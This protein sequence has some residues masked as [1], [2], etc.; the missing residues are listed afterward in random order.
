MPRGR[1]RKLSE[2]DVEE[3]M[4]RLVNGETMAALAQEYAV[5]KTTM[6]RNLTGRLTRIQGA[7]WRLARAEMQL[8]AMPPEARRAVCDLVAAMRAGRGAQK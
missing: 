3:I 8:Q 1:P 6:S 2:R 5:S 4:R 7:A